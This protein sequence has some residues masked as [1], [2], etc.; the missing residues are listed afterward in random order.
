[1]KKAFCIFVFILGLGIISHCQERF[2]NLY[3]GWC[4]NKVFV[5]DGVEGYFTCGCIGH[6]ETPAALPQFNIIEPDGLLSDSFYYTND[7]T[8]GFTSLRSRSY[9][10][11]EDTLYIS[12]SEVFYSKSYIIDPILFK[13]NIAS[14]EA[15]TIINYNY[16]S[17]VQGMNY[18]ID[19]TLGGFVLVSDYEYATYNSF[20]MII[21]TDETGDT[22]STQ[23]YEFL[24]VD[25]LRHR[26]YPYQLLPLP[27]G[28]Y[29][30]SCQDEFGS[31]PSGAKTIGACFLRLDSEGNELWRQY[32]ATEDTLCY[33][34]FAFLLEGTDEYLI[35]WSDPYLADFEN[36]P[37]NPDP[38]VNRSLWLANMDD[39]GNISNKRKVES[40]IEGFPNGHILLNDYYQDEEGNM[41]LV[42]ELIYYEQMG[43]LFKI[44]PSGEAL[45]YQQYECFPENDADLVYTKLYG[46]TPTP[47]GGFVMGGEYFSNAGNLFPAGT[48]QGLVIKVDSCGCLEEGC[49]VDCGMGVN[50]Q[51]IS[52]E[53]LDIYPNPASEIINLP[54]PVSSE[55]DILRIYDITG[56]LLTTETE[57]DT[58]S[59]T[60]NIECLKPGIYT[61]NLWPSG[62]LFTGKFIKE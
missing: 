60:I 29:L 52:S 35:S 57:I 61:I 59:G 22:L 42:G 14:Y 4:I 30:L 13:Y 12:M 39:S 19:T 54:L 40:D 50:I 44:N 2:Y 47:D 53:Q 6:P 43:F 33:H 32:T 3:D 62:K 28:G 7:T 17:G 46:L 34:P 8:D 23:K 11:C 37:Y 10:K 25:P 31:T 20:P 16:C 5:E 24:P 41:Y 56:K 21:F 27:D 1:M 26:V 38:N 55:I 49:N 58:D 18:L 9:Y 51:T 15:D 36:S 45:W 48:Q